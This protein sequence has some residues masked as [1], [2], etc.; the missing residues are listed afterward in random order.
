MVGVGNF[1]CTLYILTYMNFLCILRAVGQIL[2]YLIPGD[3]P[4]DIILRHFGTV[5]SQEIE[6][7]TIR[8]KSRGSDFC[9]KRKVYFVR[10]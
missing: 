4:Q 5:N 1:I 3:F 8:I 10:T 2:R 7:L 6:P 9:A